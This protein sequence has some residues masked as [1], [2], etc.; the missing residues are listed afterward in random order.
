[1]RIYR[2]WDLD[3]SFLAFPVKVGIL[4]G[5]VWVLALW[6]VIRNTRKRGTAAM[7]DLQLGSGKIRGKSGITQISL[8]LVGQSWPTLQHF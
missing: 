6:R 2:A 1:L 5:I 7:S 3:H 4:T 8:T